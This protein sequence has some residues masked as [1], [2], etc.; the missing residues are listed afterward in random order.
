MRK[1][2]VITMIGLLAFAGFVGLA[3]QQNAEDAKFQKLFDN[4]FDTY[5]KFYPTQAMR[6]GYYKYNDKLED[7]AESSI[8]KYLDGMDKVNAELVNKIAKDKLSPE[9][10]TDLD[11][12]RD[13]IDLDMLRLERIVPQQ[14]NPL[15]YNEIIFQSF[16]GLLTKEFAPLDARLKSATERAKALPGFIKLAKENLKTPPKEYTDAA[17]RQFRPIL[18][19]FH[20][21]LPK[22]VEP[23]GAEA[24]AKFQAEYAKA[25]PAIEDFGKF[26]EGDLQARSTGN[27]RLGEAHQRLIQLTIGGSIMLNELGAR[28][29]ADTTNIRREMFKN[30]FAYYKIMNPE[31]DIEH[32]PANLTDEQQISMVINHILRGF[33]GPRPP[34]NEDFLPRIQDAAAKLKDFIASKGLLDVPADLPVLE[35]M[36]RQMRFDQLVQLVYPAPYDPNDKFRLYI[37]PYAEMLPPD[38]AQSFNEEYSNMLIPIWTAEK[39]FPGA[40][41]PAAV[42]WNHSS[43]IQKLSPNK[44]LN[45]GWPLYAQDMFVYAGFND[46]DLRQRLMDLKLKLR[47]LIDFQLDI[48]VHEGSYTKEQAVRYMTTTG[49]VTEAEAE[50]EWNMIVTHPLDAAYAYIGY[51][52]ILDM[53]K[54]YKVA[55]GAAF[56]QKEFL[57][58]LTSYGSLPLR[59]LKTKLASGN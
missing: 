18:D 41:A 58:K 34:R 19:F 46:Y 3:G 7:F 50:R 55:K 59:F 57:Q 8:E 12:L 27:F 15:I 54:D 17:I 37:N 25:L 21:D 38:K 28:A 31:F 14:L 33:R 9:K 6:A 20:E 42:S 35:V 4:Y 32:P 39:I 47:A 5:W 43:L 44:A 11:M 51:Q 36:P 16:H 24:K 1:S 45:A 10:Q 56:S 2:A 48:N 30:C 26:L 49:F 22:L 23:A 40:F 29:K 52:E 53:E 13:W